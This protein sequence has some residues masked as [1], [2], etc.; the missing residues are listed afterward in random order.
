[1]R[2]RELRSVRV[3]QA[4]RLA[5]HVFRAVDSLALAVIALVVVDNVSDESVW[6][7]PLSGVLPYV[8]GAA[9][10]AHF[11]RTTG[12][13]R[14]TRRRRLDVQLAHVVAITVAVG[15]VV[16]AIDQVLVEES[17]TVD[18]ALTWAVATTATLITLHSVWW[19]LVR[20]WRA[21][22]FLTPNIVLVG[23]TARAETLIT[24][25][26][27][28]GDINVIGIFD[29]RLNRS[30][31][32][33]LGV[34]VLG[35]TQA[36]VTHRVAP[37]IDLIVVT[38]DPRATARVREITRRL[39][40]LPNDITLMVDQQDDRARV[41]AVAHLADSPLAPVGSVATAEHRAFAKRVQDLMIGVPLL[42]LASPVLAAVALVVKLDSR[43]PVLF[44]QRRHGFNNEEI[45]VCKFRTMRHETAD[46]TA[47]RQVTAGDIRVTRVGRVLRKTSL[48][49]VPQLLNVIRGEMSL[50]GPRPHAIGMKTGE[51][52]SATLVAEYAHRHRIKPGM[53]G[54]AAIK[55]SRGPLH[56]P[57]EVQRRVALDVDYIE[58]QSFWLDVKI[59]LLTVPS[60]FGDR[61]AVR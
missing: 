60:L 44:R 51:V 13:Y 54:W 58:R 2:P 34:P 19:L 22:G 41:A 35:N 30:P 1:M 45:M 46:A 8:G 6:Q 9:I 25:A 55:G 15:V 56:D 37:H 10:V 27:A 48:D 14:F 39:S 57:D 47:S 24:D 61:S 18:D 26:M 33:I 21:A 53:T 11:L 16:A 20:H 50:V 4:R 59:M 40:E 23:A 7:T 38:V 17:G 28:H 29:D 5:S 42:V 36:L 52:E 49:E 3:R 31:L 32:A 12:A 43:G